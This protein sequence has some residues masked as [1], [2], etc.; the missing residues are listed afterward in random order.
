MPPIELPQSP[1]TLC[2]AAD[3]AVRGSEEVQQILRGERV[4]LLPPGGLS[5]L[6][7]K[8]LLIAGTILLPGGHLFAVHDAGWGHEGMLWLMALGQAAGSSISIPGGLIV[9]GWK[10]AHPLMLRV[11]TGLLAVHVTSV[12]VAHV[13]PHEPG[14]QA[15]CW[16]GLAVMALAWRTVRGPSYALCAAVFRAKR[17][18]LKQVRTRVP[19]VR[20]G[21]SKRRRR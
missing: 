21:R 5:F 20:K 15:V 8:I 11:T 16:G 4:V 19:R 13:T 3:A 9:M 10:G 2:D 6:F 1:T 14:H 17:A 18:W 12:V 7:V